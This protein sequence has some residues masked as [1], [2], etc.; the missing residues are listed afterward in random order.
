MFSI[1]TASTGPSKMTHLR[2]GPWSEAAALK[3]TARI[4][5]D[6]SWLPPPPPPVL[7]A[8]SHARSSSPCPPSTRE[9]RPVWLL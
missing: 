6:H 8:P 2:S 7:S 4:P 3:L 9:C 1:Q 5:S